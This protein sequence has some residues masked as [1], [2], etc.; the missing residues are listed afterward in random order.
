MR[1]RGRQGGE[2]DN[3]L[4]A[5]VCPHRGHRKRLVCFR[6][7]KVSG[8]RPPSTSP[9]AA[10]PTVTPSTWPSK[11]C[12]R[13][14]RRGWMRSSS[15]PPVSSVPATYTSSAAACSARCS[16]GFPGSRPPL[17]HVLA[18]ERG[19]TS[20]RYIL[21]GENVSQRLSRN[22]NYPARRSAPPWSG[23]TPGTWRTGICSLGTVTHSA[24]QTRQLD[25]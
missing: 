16:A 18:A 7:K 21:G 25:K 24:F 2:T 23:L 10:S 15:T 4:G 22:W 8:N 17:D 3:P 11:R 6:A 19:R 9:R 12:R 1:G 5:T 20:K 13:R 14:S